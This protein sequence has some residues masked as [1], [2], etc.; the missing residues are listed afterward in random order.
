MSQERG[1]E[2]GRIAS[3]VV[4]VGG[5]PLEIFERHPGQL[6]DGD[7]R[8]ISGKTREAIEQF[9]HSTRAATEQE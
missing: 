5:K 9:L 6:R 7:E 1:P 3:T 4:T 2:D 8:N